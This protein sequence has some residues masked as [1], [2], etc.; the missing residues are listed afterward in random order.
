MDDYLRYHAELADQ[1]LARLRGLEAR[2]WRELVAHHRRDD[3]FYALALEL[4]D[5]AT[6]LLGDERREVYEAV[7]KERQQVADE[8]IAAVSRHELRDESRAESRDESR[9]E[10]LDDA[11]ATDARQLARAAVH[12]FLVRDAFGFN[13]GAF[14]E[15]IRPF[16]PYLDLGEL[17]R[18]AYRVRTPPGG[19][20]RVSESHAPRRDEG[21]SGAR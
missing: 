18:V 20:G 5:E 13:S 7:L 21:S 3:N 10:S 2:Q 9:D 1:C 12:A 6:R 16:R 11:R 15:L 17:E 14:G 4:A 8:I 19:A